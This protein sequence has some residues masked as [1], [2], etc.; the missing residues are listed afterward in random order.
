VYFYPLVMMG[1][2]RLQSI[3]TPAAQRR[4]SGPPNEFH[5]IGAFPVADMLAA[6]IGTR[7]CMPEHPE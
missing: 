6:R 1:V 5:H 3:N 4:D 2:S 7:H